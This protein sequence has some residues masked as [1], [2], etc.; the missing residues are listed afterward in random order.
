MHLHIG[1]M[2]GLAAYLTWLVLH[3]FHLIIAQLL[4]DTSFGQ[5]LAFLA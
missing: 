3:F 1:A 5:A 2:T 4:A